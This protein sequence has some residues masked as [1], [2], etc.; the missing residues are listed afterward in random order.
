MH[1]PRER[2][3]VLAHR[4]LYTNAHSSIIHNSQKAKTTQMP[5]NVLKKKKTVYPENRILLSNKKVLIH[6]EI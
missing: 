1:N 6:D 3:P 5:I 4:N 2:K